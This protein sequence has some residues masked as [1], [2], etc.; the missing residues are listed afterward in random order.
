MRDPAVGTG[1]DAGLLSEVERGGLLGVA[2]VCC[3]LLAS[4]ATL[5]LLIV[6]G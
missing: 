4:A 3:V 2:L 1:R 6:P 5:L